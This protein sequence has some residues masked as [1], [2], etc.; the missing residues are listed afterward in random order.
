MQ[1]RVVT[2][3]AFVNKFRCHESVGK[4]LVEMEKLSDAYIQFAY[5]KTAKSVTAGEGERKLF[6]TFFFMSILAK[7]NNIDFF[8]YL[9]IPIPSQCSILKIFNFESIICP[10]VTLPVC[11]NA[12]YSDIIGKYEYVAVFYSYS[13]SE[14]LSVETKKYVP[15]GTCIM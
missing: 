6:Q 9:V 10:T 14:W 8:V 1:E 4:I 2:A 15:T 12:V 13:S 11:K 7:S 5:F 3:T